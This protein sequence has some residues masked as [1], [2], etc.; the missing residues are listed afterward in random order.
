MYRLVTAN[1]ID[2]RMVEHAAAKRKLEKMVIHRE[3]FKGD[4]CG[5]NPLTLESLLE[6]LQSNEHDAEVKWTAGGQFLNDKDLRFLLDRKGLEEQC[7]GSHKLFEVV[8][9]VPSS[10]L[11]RGVSGCSP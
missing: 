1:T 10:S 2:Q 3:R 7:N 6:L 4:H 8:D 11:L 9:E 5:S